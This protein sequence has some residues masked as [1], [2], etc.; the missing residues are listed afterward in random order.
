MALDTF[1]S[2]CFSTAR[3]MLILFWLLAG[4][5]AWAGQ[6]RLLVGQPNR[7]PVGI[8]VRNVSGLLR[9][10]QNGLIRSYAAMVGVAVVLVLMATIIIVVSVV[11]AFVDMT[12]IDNRL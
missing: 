1:M 5:T 2:K 7:V 8:E 11:V 10:V 12:R 4:A 3:V 6:Y 9:K